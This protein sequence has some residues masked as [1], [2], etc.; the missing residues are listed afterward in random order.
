VIG[1]VACQQSGNWNIEFKKSAFFKRHRP[2][3]EGIEKRD[4]EIDISMC[5]AIGHSLADQ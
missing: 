3:H 5:R 2:P 4:R 1:K